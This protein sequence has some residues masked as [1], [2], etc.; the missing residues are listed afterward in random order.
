[1]PVTGE[2]SKHTSTKNLKSIKPELV[3][4]TK[5]FKGSVVTGGDGSVIILALV[6]EEGVSKTAG[7]LNE[8]FSRGQGADAAALRQ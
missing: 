1:M 3:S 5:M 4:Q 7:Y 6:C 8:F 2:S